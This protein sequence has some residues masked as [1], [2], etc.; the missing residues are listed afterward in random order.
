VSH[1]SQLLEIHI[2]TWEVRFYRQMPNF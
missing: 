1:Y 2:F